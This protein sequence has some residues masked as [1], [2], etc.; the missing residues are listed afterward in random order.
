M[1]KR[2]YIPNWVFIVLLAV[3]FLLCMVSMV[4]GTFWEESKEKAF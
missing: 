3:L 4:I 1:K 2:R